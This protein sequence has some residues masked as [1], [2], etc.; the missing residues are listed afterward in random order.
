MSRV[1]WQL[2]P[3]CRDSSLPSSPIVSSPAALSSPDEQSE[4]PQD[5]LSSSLRYA[6]RSLARRHFGPDETLPRYVLGY[7]NIRGLA[8]WVRLLFYY[9]G[10]PFLERTY[11]Y[12]DMFLWEKDKFSLPE[13][14]FPNLP[15][16]IILPDRGRSVRR[17]AVDGEEPFSTRSQNSRT[18]SLSETRSSPSLSSRQAKKSPKV[19]AS[20]LTSGQR[21][22]LSPG[23]DQRTLRSLIEADPKARVLTESTAIA[24]TLARELGAVADARRQ[25]FVDAAR[26]PSQQQQHDDSTGDHVVPPADAIGTS[27]RRPPPPLLESFLSSALLEEYLQV[28]GVLSDIYGQFSDLCYSVDMSGVDDYPGSPSSSS[29]NAEER[30]AREV[31]RE[32]VI[33]KYLEVVIS[34]ENRGCKFGYL[35]GWLGGPAPGGPRS[36][37]DTE[38]MQEVASGSANSALLVLP[39][40]GQHQTDDPNWAED[41]PRGGSG[42]RTPARNSSL[43]VN[44]QEDSSATNSR[45]GSSQPNNPPSQSVVPDSLE[46]MYAELPTTLRFDDFSEQAA[47]LLAERGRRF[48][49]SDLHLSALDFKLWSLLDYHLFLEPNCLDGVAGTTRGYPVLREFYNDIANMDFVRQ[50]TEDG[51]RDLAV[52]IYGKRAQQ[53]HL[54]GYREE[55]RGHL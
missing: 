48:L 1:R 49:F 17:G 34:S 33:E 45:P 21:V 5:G 31:R 40:E 32:A 30:V 6:S 12:K 39:S 2:F 23:V 7:W 8:D 20:R 19:S 3:R 15:Y 18:R 43:R 36:T 24:W 14:R 47:D 42:S 35:E 16:L 29:L 46:E 26:S 44:E 13:M 9:H 50:F 27:N 22:E 11:P 38:M 54:R 28:S 10:V 37:W 41:G 53:G 25:E 55:R 52:P 4:P 51:L